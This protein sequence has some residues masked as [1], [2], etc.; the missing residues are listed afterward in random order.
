MKERI[1]IYFAA[2][3]VGVS[4]EFKEKINNVKEILQS[5]VRLSVYDPKEYGNGATNKWGHNL[6]EW[7]RVIFELDAAAIKRCDW[8]VVCDF[9]RYGTSGTAWECG[10]AFG[11]RKKVFVVEMDEDPSTSYSVMIRGCSANYCKYSELVNSDIEDL[12]ETWFVERGRV[13]D[14]NGTTLD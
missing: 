5:S 1:N 3:I 14:Y 2:P 4:D 6:D 12:V 11:L 13:A 10:Y 8:I 9:G 7:C